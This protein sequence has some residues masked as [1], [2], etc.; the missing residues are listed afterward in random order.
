MDAAISTDDPGY[1]FTPSENRVRCEALSDEIALL[2]GHLNAAN[3]RLLK[4]IAEFDTRK[5]WGAEGCQSCAH[6]LNYKCGIDMGAAREKVRTANALVSLPKISEA[7]E[8]GQISYSKARA[9]TRVA[10]PYTEENLLMVARHGTADHVE[11]Y[12]RHFRRC[13]EVEE[14]GREAEQQANRYLRYS[15]EDD[16][17]LLIKGR[18]PAET[19]ALLL[20]A[21]E[22]GI[23]VLPSTDVSAETRNPKS[24]PTHSTH[25]VKRADVLALMA[26]SFLAHGDESLSGGERH[27]VVVHVSAETLRSSEPGQ[28]EFEDGASMAAETAR[29]LSCDA[30]VVAMVENDQGEPLNVGRKTRSIPP[31]LRRALNARDQGCR[32]P[33]CCNRKHVDGHH[34]EHWAHGGETKLRNLISLCH[35]HHHLV[36]EG[37]F[38]MQVLDDG[39]FRFVK[40]DGRCFDTT[41]NHHTLQFGWK[42]LPVAHEKSGIHINKRTAVTLWL[43]DRMDYGHG[44]ECLLHQWRRGRSVSAETRKV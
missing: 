12:V 41:A 36:H 20:K 23:Q 3:Y 30:S 28:C 18:L 40:P 10:C 16:G 35:F 32:F 44:V 31:A 19:G 26:E 38:T 17:S 11:T 8:Q 34:V 27:Q 6:W 39:A 2:A 42:E 29:R 14:L 7:M 5:G 37:G 24:K 22:A 33:G 43:G 13:K 25:S 1:Y 9:I 21:F 4:L 15:W